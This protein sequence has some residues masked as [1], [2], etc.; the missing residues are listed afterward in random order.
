MPRAMRM[1][2]ARQRNAT[3]MSRSTA[4]QKSPR[5]RDLIEATTDHSFEVVASEVAVSPA[6]AEDHCCVGSVE[7]EDTSLENVRLWIK[8]PTVVQTAVLQEEASE[9]GLHSLS[10][11]R[12]T[13]ADSATSQ[14]TGRAIVLTG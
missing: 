14:V 1:R 11:S 9:E 10:E 13:H 5:S 8:A 2:M 3:T 12:E 4:S 7:D 6:D